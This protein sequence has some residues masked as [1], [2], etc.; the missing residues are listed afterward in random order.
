M[1]KNE[2]TVKD[3]AEYLRVCV[4]TVHELE[5]TGWLIPDYRVKKG[6]RMDRR[7]TRE[8]I[9]KFITNNTL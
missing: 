4:Q 8:T 1:L 3:V 6:P 2:M 5:R 9:E 7:Y